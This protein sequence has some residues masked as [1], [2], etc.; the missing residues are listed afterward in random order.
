MNPSANL[1][2]VP[3]TLR[4][5]AAARANP[6]PMAWP[7]TAEITGMGSVWIVRIIEER[8]WCRLSKPWAT[9]S[10]RSPIAAA[11][12]ASLAATDLT[13]IPAQNAVCPAPVRMIARHERSAA[14][15]LSAWTRSSVMFGAN[16]LNASGLFNVTTTEVSCRSE[17]IVFIKIWV[18]N[19]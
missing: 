12:E 11:A 1:A 17:S 18:P 8:W 2:F 14:A 16:A 10:S 13:S 19:G 15:S 5:L 3:A 9:G 6:A 7:L 4:S